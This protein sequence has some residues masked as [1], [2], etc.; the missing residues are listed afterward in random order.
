MASHIEMLRLDGYV[1]S[2]ESPATACVGGGP[3]VAPRG[4]ILA[5]AKEDCR[6]QAL[7]FTFSERV[8]LLYDSGDSLQE[9]RLVVSSC[10][11]FYGK[12]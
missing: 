12:C 5:K 8:F 9:G 6:W 4:R 1:P 10:L 3:A 11:L 2:G 7:F